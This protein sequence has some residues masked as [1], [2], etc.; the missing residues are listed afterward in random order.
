MTSTARRR[1][2]KQRLSQTTEP[3]SNPPV[4]PGV[5]GGRFKPLSPEEVALVEETALT[6]LETLGL[7]QA[8][9]SMID[10]VLVAGGSLSSDNRLLFPRALVQQSITEAKRNFSLC[11]QTPEHDLDIS[12]AR[13][14]MSSGGAAPGVFDLETGNYRDSTL[15]DL[16]DAARIVDQMDN[17]HHFSRSVVARD[18]EDNAVMDLNTAYACLAGTSKHVSISIS[19]PENVPAIAQLCYAVAGSEEAFRARPFLTVMVCHVVPPMRFAEEACEVLEAAI[20][21][22]FPVQLISAGQAGA[23]SPATIA[24]SLVQAVAET[25]AGLVF[26]RLVDPEVKAI[27]APKPLVADLRT[28]SMCGGGGEQAILM[29]GA[30]QMGRHFDLPTS[31]IAGITDAKCLD[32]Q[33]GA[34]KSLAVT[35]AAH[36]GSNIVTQAAGMQASLL[37]VSHAAYVSDNDM[38][39]NILRTL[40][41]VEATPE[42]IAADLIAEVCRGEG[43][44]LGEQHTFNRMKSDYF[45]PEIG[46]R[47]TPREW[48]EDG[49]RPVGDIA[50]DKARE[51]LSSQFPQHIPDDVDRAL[52][53][54][55]DIRLT[56]KQTG[57][58][59]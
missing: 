17:I 52:R 59:S 51:I 1:G 35:M 11:G 20:L 58:F 9:P 19:E 16:Y 47:R 31:S 3:V 4:W 49:S 28:G 43:H 8:I 2:R 45:Y 23:T 5:Y 33:Y 32:A 53:A 30:A 48:H 6:L 44:Y 27:F 46:D 39:G 18:I 15:A 12:Q 37:G 13:V 22:G 42:N 40:R 26:A 55:F 29:A 7:S 36:A 56:R 38:L 10:K 24:G 34:E 14:H 50:R 57:R 54:R 41:G 25:L 21:A